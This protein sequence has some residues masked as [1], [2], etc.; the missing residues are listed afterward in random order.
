MNNKLPFE[1]K[2]H[3]KSFYGDLQ[4]YCGTVL[5][6][7]RIT[8]KTREFEQEWHMSQFGVSCTNIKPY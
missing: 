2:K 4:L 8:N 6:S 3:G 1:Q 5:P 7:F